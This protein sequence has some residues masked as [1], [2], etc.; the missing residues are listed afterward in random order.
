MLKMSTLLVNPVAK[1]IL[2]TQILNKCPIVIL[3][4]T[5][6]IKARLHCHV[7]P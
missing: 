7:Y 6:S 3:R 5:M 2:D 4:L 1:V